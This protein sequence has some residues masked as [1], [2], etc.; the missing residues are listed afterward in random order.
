MGYLLRH[1]R[2]VPAAIAIVSAAALAIALA[3][4][5]LGGLRPCVLCEYQRYA[6]AAALLCALAGLVAGLR[7][8]ARRWAVALAGLSLLAG[9][10]IAFYH[11]GV[12]QHWWLGTDA[13]RA[14]GFDPNITAAQLREQMRTEDFAPCDRVA[15]SLLGISIAGYNFLASLG[16]GVATLW[17]AARMGPGR[18]A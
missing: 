1:P 15:W 2:W 10:A 11:V 5:Y 13:C 4:Q 12:E 16:I 17:A 7:A 14:A 3:A 6:Y 8:R 9:A 18:A